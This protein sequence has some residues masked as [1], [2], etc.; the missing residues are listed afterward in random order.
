[1]VQAPSVSSQTQGGNIPNA[2]SSEAIPQEAG[3]I[4]PVHQNFWNTS[5]T[6]KLQCSALC[7][8]QVDVS[9]LSYYVTHTFKFYFY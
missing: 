6:Y 1:M 2:R 3:V 8:R 7:E 5:A 4:K 9:S